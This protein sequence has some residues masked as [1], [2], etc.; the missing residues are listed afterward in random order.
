MLVSPKP[1]AD[2][3]RGCAGGKIRDLLFATHPRRH[4]IRESLGTACTFRGYD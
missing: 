2:F 4:T 1:A 3:S